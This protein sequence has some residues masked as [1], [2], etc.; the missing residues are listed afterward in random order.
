MDSCKT[1]CMGDAGKREQQGTVAV[2]NGNKG[3]CARYTTSLGSATINL[4]LSHRFGAFTKAYI[5]YLVE[6][7]LV[8]CRIPQR[9]L[10]QKALPWTARKRT[11]RT[12]ERCSRRGPAVP[13]MGTYLRL[14][15]SLSSPGSWAQ[16]SPMKGK[17][18]WIN[19]CIH[20]SLQCLY[21]KMVPSPNPS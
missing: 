6:T 4:V 13:W 3:N 19:V 17:R 7:P 16:T 9:N 18:P 11:R 10:K 14:H 2:P 15:H 12:E 20:F 8:P 5:P 21:F 1:E